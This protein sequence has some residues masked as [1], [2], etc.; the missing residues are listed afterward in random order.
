MKSTQDLSKADF[1]ALVGDTLTVGGVELTV[2]AVSDGK[3]QGGPVTAPFSVALAAAEPTGAPAF[4]RV[5]SVSH[6]AIGEHELFVS[7]IAS[8]A[9][10]AVYQIL[11]N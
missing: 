1:E 11:F 8:R 4:S 2:E 3:A 10:E 5:V 9:D 7:R 6:E